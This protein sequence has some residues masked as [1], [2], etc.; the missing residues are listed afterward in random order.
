M[1]LAQFLGWM[2]IVYNQCAWIG[3]VSSNADSGVAR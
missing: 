3:I 1:Q 2:K